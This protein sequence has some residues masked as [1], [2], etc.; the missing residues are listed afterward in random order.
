[1][2]QNG[3]P[4]SAGSTPAVIRVSVMIPMVFCASLVPWASETIDAETIWP[5]LNPLVTVPFAARAVIR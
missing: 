1:M 2:T 5:I 3:G 4:A